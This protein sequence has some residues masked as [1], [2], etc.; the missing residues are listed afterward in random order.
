MPQASATPPVLA[1]REV[2]ASEVHYAA[3]WTIPLSCHTLQIRNTMTDRTLLIISGTNRPAS[4]TLRFARMVEKH[5]QDAQIKTD[6]LSL[7]DLP[8]E[9]FDGTSYATKPPGMVAIQQRVLSAA[10]LHIVTPEYNGSF[11]GVLK[12]FIDMLKFPESFEHKPVAF[13]SVANGMWGG[14]RAVEQLQMIFGYR[15]AHSY[16]DR[17]FVPTVGKQ[18]DADGKLLDAALDAR[19][20]KQCIGFASFAHV[21]G[22]VCEA[23]PK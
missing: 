21:I 5:Y 15:N 3:Q 11:P 22:Q 6:F 18:L 17:V 14:L 4:N 2:V 16:P 13:V 7:T 12:Y 9:V 10:G 1:S 8:R 20:K 23:A 19:L